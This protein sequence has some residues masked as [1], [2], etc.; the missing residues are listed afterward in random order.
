LKLIS[1]RALAHG[2]L[3]VVFLLGVM[4]GCQTE[5]PAPPQITVNITAV[6]DQGAVDNAVQATLTEIGQQQAY[7]RET[8]LAL[9]GI[10]LTP[11]PTHTT[12]FTPPPPTGTPTTP[13]SRTP[14]P[15]DTPTATYIPYSSNTPEPTLENSDEFSEETARIRVLHAW[16]NALGQISNPV[17]LFINETRVYRALDM[18]GATP[19]IQV[20]PGIVRLSVASVDI[21]DELRIPIT[22]FTVEIAPGS[23]MTLLLINDEGESGARFFELSDDIL[24]LNSGTARLSI[25]NAHP[26]LIP[27]NLLLTSQRRSFAYNFRYGDLIGP[28][29]VPLG[30]YPLEFFD[31]QNPEQLLTVLDD[32]NIRG[33][34]NY[35]MVITPPNNRLSLLSY[36]LFEGSTIPPQDEALASFVNA[37]PSFGGVDLALDG[38]PVYG[39]L[40]TGEVTTQLPIP[41]NGVKFDIDA[42]R[43]LYEGSLGPWTGQESELDKIVLMVER[44]ESTGLIQALPV[45]FFQNPRPSAIRTNLRLIN[46]LSGATRSLD[47]EIRAVRYIEV[48][49]DEGQPE[50]RREDTEWVPLVQNISFSQ[51]SDYIVRSPDT[52]DVRVVISGTQSVVASIDGLQLLAGGVYDFVVVPIAQQGQARLLLVQ[53]QA[54]VSN[55]AAQVGDPTTVAE[56]VNA[57]QTALAPA[58]I[59]SPTT[60]S[61]PTPTITPIPTNTPG[62]T[63]TPDFLP[64]SI[65]VNPAPPNTASEDFVLVGQNF[66]PNRTFVIR[67]DDNPQTVS[68]GVVADDGTIAIIVPVPV[69]VSSGPHVVRICVDCV[70]LNGVNQEAFTVINIADPAVTPT[71]TPRP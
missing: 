39:N 13:P 28:M 29:D 70:A 64:P 16:R 47:L 22:G 42:D 61:T 11:S 49:N 62:P 68:S 55:L 60:V 8:E 32:V 57:T 35:V 44:Q 48:M 53:P 9:G 18:G 51:G 59:A 69:G 21:E 56:I 5:V 43:K 30:N 45:V 52:F 6:S 10:T 54:Q 4:A 25:V 65:L 36:F 66:E 33:T 23:S 63:N 2:C 12:T 17:D 3:W 37:S 19:Y 38:Q 27:T 15:S 67:F 7:I 14:T 26:R 71:Q 20:N 50:R 31:S 24:P 40:E 1:L 41:N 46:G 58:V 34:L